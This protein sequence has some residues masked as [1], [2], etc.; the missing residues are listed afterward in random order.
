MSDETIEQRLITA[1]ND[2]VRAY[3][4]AD[5]GHWNSYWRAGREPGHIV[6]HWGNESGWHPK[7]FAQYGA[8]EFGLKVIGDYYDNY[9]REI[10]IDL[11]A[12]AN[13]EESIQKIQTDVQRLQADNTKRDVANVLNEVKENMRHKLEHNP[14]AAFAVEMCEQLRAYANTLATPPLKRPDHLVVDSRYEDYLMQKDMQRAA[15]AGRE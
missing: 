5:G 2:Y 14:D 12:Q 9:L 8:K 3:Q 13:L 4:Y 1:L 10:S 6:C 7:A 11:S 15:N